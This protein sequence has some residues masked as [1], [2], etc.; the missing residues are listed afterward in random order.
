MTMM[1]GEDAI[2]IILNAN[3]LIVLYIQIKVN[4][5]QM[6]RM[7]LMIAYGEVHHVGRKGM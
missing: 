6:R 5:I 3:L 1:F 2:G 7:Y 4:V